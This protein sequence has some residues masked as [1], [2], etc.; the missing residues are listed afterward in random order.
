M[1]VCPKC[2]KKFGNEIG[3]CGDCGVQLQE[4]VEMNT[5]Q[6]SQPVNQISQKV[7]LSRMESCASAACSGIL[8]LLKEDRMGKGV[9]SMLTVGR[10]FVFEVVNLLIAYNML[11]NCMSLA[12]LGSGK[13][14]PSGMPS[15]PSLTPWLILCIVNYGF[16]TYLI[17]KRLR[18]VGLQENFVKG[19]AGIFGFLSAYAI[20]TIDSSIDKIIEAIFSGIAGGKGNALFSMLTSAND[21]VFACKVIIGINLVALL[22]A[23]LKGSEDDNQYG[24]KPTAL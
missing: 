19:G 16:A 1:K 12:Q 17:F 23:F 13:G 20:Y 21:F 14:L 10:L 9:Y 11:D 18:D 22:V 5:A 3:F 4:S 2:G 24:K 15:I 8:A 7:D 6:V